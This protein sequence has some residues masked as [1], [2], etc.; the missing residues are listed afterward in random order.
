MFPY[1]GVKNGKYIQYSLIF[2]TLS[3]NKISRCQLL[4]MESELPLGILLKGGEIMNRKKIKTDPQGS[5]TG[6]PE[7]PTEK[8]VQDADD[9]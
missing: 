4:P 5:Y 6:R 7:I 9:L 8:P 2:H 1:F 3:G